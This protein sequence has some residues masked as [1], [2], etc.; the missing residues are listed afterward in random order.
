MTPHFANAS[1]PTCDTTFT[2]VPVHGDE[3]GAYAALEL[4]PCGNCGA[5]LCPCCEQFQCCGCAQIFCLEHLV[6]VPD[7]TSNPLRCCTTCAAE[8]EAIE[9]PLPPLRCACCQNVIGIMDSLTGSGEDTWHTHC[10][11]T[12]QER[13]RKAV[14]EYD[15]LME[16]APATPKPMG[17]AGVAAGAQTEVA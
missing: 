13:L 14:Q 6:N 1:C 16:S 8:V 11:N 9:L 17:V 2:R 7:G 12:S 4:K 5:L 15:E 10:W 3:D